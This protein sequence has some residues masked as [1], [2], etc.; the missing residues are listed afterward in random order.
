MGDRK[1]EMILRRISD[2]IRYQDWFTVMV[3]ILIMLIGVFIG[4]QVNN[5]NEERVDSRRELLY[6][7]ART[8]IAMEGA[9]LVSDTYTNLTGSGDL[10]IIKSQTVKNATSS[11]LAGPKRSSW[12]PTRTSRSWSIFSSLS[13]LAKE[14][15][16]K[17]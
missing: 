9:P 15:E 6:Q 13:L 11:F 17:Q 7:A 1:T 4:L 2:G 14:L 10:A 16:S 8:L 3:E 12:Y 5:W